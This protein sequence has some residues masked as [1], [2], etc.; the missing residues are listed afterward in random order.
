M[1]FLDFEMRTH[2]ATGSSETKCRPDKK[3]LDQAK[4][5]R[6]YSL[7]LLGAT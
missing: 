4:H 6:L 7:S 5:F 2:Q 3:H 1:N